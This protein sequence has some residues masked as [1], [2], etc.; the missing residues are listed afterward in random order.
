MKLHSELQY[1]IFFHLNNKISKGMFILNELKIFENDEFGK[2]RMVE[3]NGEPYF[4]G[5]DIAEIL[6]YAKPLNA[7]AAHVDADDSL[8]QGLTDSMGRNQETIFI[9]ESGLYSLVLS[10]KLPT[11]KRFKR[12][13]T[14]DVLPSIRK[15]GVYAVDELINDPELAIKVFTALK[16][17]RFKNKELSTTIAI[18]NQQIAEMQPK[19]TYYD[20]VL[21]CKDLVPISV[22]AKD[23]GWSA[24]RM[25]QYLHSKGVQYKQGHIWLLYQ[26]YAEAGYTS[27]KIKLYKDKTGDTHSI[28]HTYWSQKGRLF[29]YDTLKSDDILPLIERDAR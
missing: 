16:E 27:T 23:Y 8:K 1:L 12:W 22:I 3:V 5:K 15:H 2:I 19:A 7:L 11:A 10:S 20:L 4:V 21:N 9:N 18:Q 13:V 17:E 6:G 28:P 25:N 26:K 24:N 29:I 14:S